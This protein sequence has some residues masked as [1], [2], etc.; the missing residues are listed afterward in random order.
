MQRKTKRLP[1]MPPPRIL[2]YPS[3]GS[4]KRSQ[5]KFLQLR[6]HSQEHLLF[7]E[8][9]IHRYHNQILAEFAAEQGLAF[10]WTTAAKLE[11]EHPDLE[12]LGG[13]RFRLDLVSGTLDLWDDSKAY[14]RFREQGLAERIAAAEA[15]WGELQVRIG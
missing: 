14:G 13:G 3:T 12:V 8:A 9:G 6:W 4:V 5:G 10:R 1:K 15:P 7:A 2:H 11:L